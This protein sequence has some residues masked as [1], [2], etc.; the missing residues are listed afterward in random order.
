[1]RIRA[2]VRKWCKD[3][4]SLPTLDKEGYIVGGKWQ[5]TPEHEEYHKETD[6]ILYED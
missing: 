2:I 4:H 1:M 3:C 6:E 5:T